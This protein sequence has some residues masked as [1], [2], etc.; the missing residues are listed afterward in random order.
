MSNLLKE[1]A[2]DELKTHPY[3]A[4]ISRVHKRCT[5]TSRPR[6]LVTRYVDYLLLGSYQYQG[7]SICWLL[8]FDIGK[9]LSVPIKLL[10]F[11]YMIGNC[12]ILFVSHILRMGECRDVRNMT[13]QK[14]ENFSKFAQQR[15]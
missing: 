14:V 9:I 6:G 2:H 15:L 4:S 7:I 5:I 1:M 11:K 13:E 8:V 12:C 3:D 10:V